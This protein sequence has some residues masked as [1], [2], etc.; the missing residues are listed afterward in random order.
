VHDGGAF[1]V[2]YTLP[3]AGA[4][5][6]HLFVRAFVRPGQRFRDSWGK[7]YLSMMPYYVYVWKSL[8]D[9]I[10]YVVSSQSASPPRPGYWKGKGPWKVV[11]KEEHKD[12]ASAMRRERQIKS[13]KSKAYIDSLG[14]DPVR[15]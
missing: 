13:R 2:V 15:T 3:S 12:R 5:E 8:G 14:Q 6:A 1:V 11:Y 9:G 10:Y 4:G 7:A